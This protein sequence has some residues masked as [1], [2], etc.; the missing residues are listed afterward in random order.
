M[1]AFP[2][3][4]LACVHC[5]FVAQHLSL[6]YSCAGSPLEVEGHAAVLLALHP[7]LQSARHSQSTNNTSLLYSLLFRSTSL[8][9]MQPKLILHELH[10]DPKPYFPDLIGAEVN[11]LRS[12]DNRGPFQQLFI[13]YSSLQCTASKSSLAQCTRSNFR[14]KF[15]ARLSRVT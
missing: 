7:W 2:A 5:T 13:R 6:L 11:K 12:M 8:K 1:K 4:Q 15:K 3:E 10:L 9:P 14:S